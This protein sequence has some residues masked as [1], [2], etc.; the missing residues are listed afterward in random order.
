MGSVQATIALAQAMALIEQAQKRL[1][2]LKK[3]V[4][5]VRG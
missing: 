2:S 1:Q 4:T 5:H 3:G